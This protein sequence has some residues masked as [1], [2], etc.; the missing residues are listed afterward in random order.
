MSDLTI[1]LA[2]ALSQGST[3]TRDELILKSFSH[4]EYTDST[5]RMI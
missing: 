2:K 3:K 4:M 5:E 1:S